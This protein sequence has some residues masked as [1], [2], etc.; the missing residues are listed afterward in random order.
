MQNKFE[1]ILNNFFSEAMND[2]KDELHEHANKFHI[3][4]IQ[5]IH[6]IDNSLTMIHEQTS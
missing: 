2:M 5:K 6:E 3:D 4:I 1:Y